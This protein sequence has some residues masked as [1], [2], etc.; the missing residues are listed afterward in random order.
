M[1]KNE[2]SMVIVGSCYIRTRIRKFRNNYILLYFMSIR[3]CVQKLEQIL[4]Q[5]VILEKIPPVQSDN[6]FL[7]LQTNMHTQ[8]VNYT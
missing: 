6:Y 1:Q 7:L 3:V 8:F 5:N 4:L 2:C